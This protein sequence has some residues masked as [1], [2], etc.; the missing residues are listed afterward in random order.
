MCPKNTKF[1]F[2]RQSEAGA[3]EP[4]TD[5]H[6]LVEGETIYFWK[7]E[8][9]G[10]CKAKIVKGSRSKGSFYFENGDEIGVLDYDWHENCWVCLAILS[11]KTLK[12]ILK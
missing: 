7:E 11:R 2:R 10:Y 6:S 4:V 5:R 1:I 3:V 9:G 8:G 12:E